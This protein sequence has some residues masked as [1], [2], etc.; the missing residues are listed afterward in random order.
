MRDG[1]RD[2]HRHDGSRDHNTVTHRPHKTAAMRSMEKK[3]ETLKRETLKADREIEEL[4]HK[5]KKA[6][7]VARTAADEV[8]ADFLRTAAALQ[9]KLDA[10]SDEIL[11]LRAANER[12]EE[13]LEE[14]RQKLREQEES[15]AE[16]RAQLERATQER[17]AALHEEM[18]VLRA[19]VEPGGRTPPPG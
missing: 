11:Q 6:K 13:E 19:G 8:K 1:V 3:I 15:N 14:L 16:H 18:E 9:S 17:L 4:E 7:H 12:D 10:D 5:K 2:P